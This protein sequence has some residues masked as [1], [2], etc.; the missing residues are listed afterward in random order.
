MGGNPT[1]VVCRENGETASP[2]MLVGTGQ[3]KAVDNP[4]PGLE[5]RWRPNHPCRR[6]KAYRVRV[7]DCLGGRE[8]DAADVGPETG[9]RNGATAPGPGRTP[10][11]AAG[12]TRT[13]LRQGG[14]HA[15]RTGAHVR[16]RDGVGAGS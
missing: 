7:P 13:Q 4:R 15:R 3:G 10:R 1:S 5:V 12:T 16:P 14:L 2:R 8:G 6:E 9:D 11:D